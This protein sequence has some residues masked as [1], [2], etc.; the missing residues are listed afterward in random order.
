MPGCGQSPEL[1]ADRLNRVVAQG[2]QSAYDKVFG[3]SPAWRLPAHSDGETGVSGPALNTPALSVVVI[4]RNDGRAPGAL[5]PIHRA[6]RP[7]RRSGSTIYVDSASVD[8]SPARAASM[9]AKVITV[10]PS[11]PTAALGRNAGWRAASA[12]FVL[13]LDGDTI[14]APRFVMEALR[15]FDDKDRDCVGTPAGNRHRRVTL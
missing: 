12:E 4:G 5:P 10:Q 9:G 13:F 14:L 2:R 8:G 11:R 3:S 1:G 6:G 15:H 7:S